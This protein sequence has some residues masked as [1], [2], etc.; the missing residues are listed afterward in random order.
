M[1][2]AKYEVIANQRADAELWRTLRNTGIGASEIAGVLSIS[3]WSSPL[4]VYATKREH[5]PEKADNER[6]K[7]GRILEPIIMAEA[8]GEIGMAV[9]LSGDLIRS[10]EYPFLLATLDAVLTDADGIEY[11]LEVKTDSSGAD[12]KDG[13][14]PHY[15]VQVQQ[16]ILV[17]GAPHGYIAVLVSGSR[18]LW[19]KVERNDAF[20]EGTLIPA[21]RRFWSMVEQGI[22]PEPDGTEA[23]RAALM[24]LYPKDSGEV[25]ALPG[26]LIELDE[27]RVVLKEEIEERKAK[28]DMID[29]EIRAALGAASVGILPSGVSYSYKWQQRREHVVP[30][31]EGR[32]LRR[33][34][35]KGAAR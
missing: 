22:E 35:A 13:I 29:N 28:L 4:M 23:T 6:M 14:P 18:L 30:A 9:R 21:A 19:S 2:T 12:W 24:A 3:P 8:G 16:Q 26:T 27:A 1:A 32:V 10:V 7:W 17:T 20:I 11:P 15:D 5:A 34:K 33:M 31:W 25:I